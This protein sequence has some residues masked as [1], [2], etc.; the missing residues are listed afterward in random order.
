MTIN[1]L[2]MTII[3]GVGTLIGPILGAA[4]VQLLG[5]WLN[6]VFGSQWQLIFGAVYV[7]LVVFLPYGIVGT[8]Y[9]RRNDIRAG[10]Q[11]LTRPLHLSEKT[12]EH[13]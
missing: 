6:S 13:L 9:A 1:A 11:R 5:Y 3:G 4:L 10:W 2:L 7:L 8:Y 12:V